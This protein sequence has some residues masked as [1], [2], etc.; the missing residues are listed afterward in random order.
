MLFSK[1]T[2]LKP[3]HSL[4]K[5]MRRLANCCIL[6]VS[7]LLLVL[8][9]CSKNFLEPSSDGSPGGLPYRSDISA[10]I[11]IVDQFATEMLSRHYFYQEEI[12]KDMDRLHYTTCSDPITAVRCLRKSHDKWTALYEDI[13]PVIANENL[14]NPS[15]GYHLLYGT[16]DNA[17]DEYC[18]LIGY[19]E[20]NSP[21]QKAGLGRGLVIT[22]VNHQPITEDNLSLLENDKSVIVGLGIMDEDMVVHDLKIEIQLTAAQYKTSPILSCALLTE[23]HRNIGYL[24]L[25]DF[26]L[27]CIEDLV[28]RFKWLKDSDCSDMVLD[29][30]YSSRGYALTEQVLAS[31]LAPHEAVKNGAVY[32]IRKFNP[33]KEAENKSSGISPEVL[34]QTRF[35][36]L[37]ESGQ[38]RSVNIEDSALGLNRLYVLTSEETAGCAEALIASLK[39][40]MNVT[41][42]GKN[43]SGVYLSGIIIEASLSNPYQS[44]GKWGL[45]VMTAATANKDGL[46]RLGPEGIKEDAEREESP[47]DGIALGNPEERMLRYALGLITG[48]ISLTKSES[49]PSSAL[50]KVQKREHSGYRLLN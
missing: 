37:D 36:Y 19:V 14:S 7:V 44:L 23:Q 3:H 33:Q 48:K 21:A 47:Q 30:R 4:N 25:T 5:D 27:D 31:L 24:C 49:A 17:P 16:Y 9:G 6:T 8:S 11:Q 2:N 41:V 35:D 28:S 43:T 38:S 13:T 40:Y 1:R 22:S 34:F 15:I 39:S 32:Q 42:I 18:V 46:M 29:L 45:H 26:T 12:L 50:H 10:E 20:E